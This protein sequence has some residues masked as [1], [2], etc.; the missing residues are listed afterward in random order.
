[1]S[2]K[3]SI[4]SQ[5]FHKILTKDIMKCSKIFKIFQKIITASKHDSNVEFLWLNSKEKKF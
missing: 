4:F 5:N 3:T 1:M 2:S